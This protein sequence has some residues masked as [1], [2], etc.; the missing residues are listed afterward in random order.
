METAPSPR[1]WIGPAII[2]AFVAIAVVIGLA[3]RG[4]KGNFIES[5]EF[6]TVMDRTPSGQSQ[7]LPGRLTSTPISSFRAADNRWCRS[8]S[9][10]GS[11]EGTGIVCRRDGEWASEARSDMRDSDGTLAAARAR[12]GARTVSQEEEAALL[13]A[14]WQ[15]PAMSPA[16]S[17]PER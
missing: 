8:Y 10:S 3:P 9:L 6:Q 7:P 2:T 13:A 12:L 11:I 17:P 4:P 5:T 14:Q 16:P 15:S 1:R